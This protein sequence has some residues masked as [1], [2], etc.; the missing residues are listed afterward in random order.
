MVGRGCDSGDVF[1]RLGDPDASQRGRR[2]PRPGPF[3]E[4]GIVIVRPTTMRPRNAWAVSVLALGLA[5]CSGSATSAETS[6]ATTIVSSPSASTPSADERDRATATW[7]IAPSQ[8]LDSG[9]TRFATLVTRLECNSGVTGT[10]N[11]PAIRVTADK[12]V[13]T[14]TVSP[15]P[16]RPAH[17]QTNDA[18][19]YVVDLPSPLGSRALVD[20]ACA[21]AEA[22]RTR[23]CK[24]RGV[25][26]NA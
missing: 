1:T 6:G 14:F 25:R 22:A 8:A 5:G 4:Q 21:T 20:G 15:G 26:R 13:I 3:L 10:V 24:D 11:P 16:P 23:F 12:V 7:E 18:V 2:G 17:C 9:S 19:A